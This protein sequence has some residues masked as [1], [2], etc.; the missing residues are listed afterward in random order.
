MCGPSEVPNSREAAK[1]LFLVCL[2]LRGLPNAS[3]KSQRFS[4]AIAQ[5]ATPEPEGPKIEKN[6]SRLKFS[7]SLEIFNLD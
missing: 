5:I 3:A 2:G 7:I 1:Q 4:Y 6:Q